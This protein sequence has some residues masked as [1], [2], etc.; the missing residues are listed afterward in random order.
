[1][2]IIFKINIETLK[3][4]FRRIEYYFTI[5]KLVMLV[6]DVVEMTNK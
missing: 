3:N 6:I 5:V 2:L 1:M 4:I